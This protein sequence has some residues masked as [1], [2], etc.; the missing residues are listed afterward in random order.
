MNMPEVTAQVQVQ[1][2]VQVE[3]Q[4]AAP[5]TLRSSIGRTPNGFH[6]RQSRQ[7]PDNLFIVYFALFFNYTYDY[8][9]I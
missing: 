3:L 6:H 9:D 4:Q 1:V 2:Q 7:V 8:S 5:T